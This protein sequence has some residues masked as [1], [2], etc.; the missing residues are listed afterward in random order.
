MTQQ[1]IDAFEKRIQQT[2][3]TLTINQRKDYYYLASLAFQQNDPENDPCARA[4]SEKFG[5]STPL[6]LHIVM[7]ACYK[8]LTESEQDAD[9][10]A[11]ERSLA[12]GPQAVLAS[13]KN[14]IPLLALRLEKGMTQKELAAKSGVN[15]RQIRRIEKGEADARNV[16]ASNIVALAD[17]LGVDVHA[18]LPGD[19]EWTVLTPAK[20]PRSTK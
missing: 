9:Y 17:A 16:A 5:D 14:L 2:I 10:R 18:L 20:K 4:I 3:S 6:T 15:E 12:G 8:A 7:S 19:N 1:E 13:T 11:A